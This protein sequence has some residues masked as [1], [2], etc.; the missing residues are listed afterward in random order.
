MDLYPFKSNLG[1]MEPVAMPFHNVRIIYGNEIYYRQVL[2][3]EPIPPFQAVDVGA[4]GAGATNANPT[5]ITNLRQFNH[6][7][8]QFRW[9]PIDH[10]QVTM[11]LPQADGKFRMKQLI[12]PVDE[13]VIERDPD[14]HLTE[15]FVWEANAPWVTCLNYTDYNI[16]R[17]RIVAMGY[18]YLVTKEELPGEVVQQIN[19]GQVPCVTVICTG[20]AGATR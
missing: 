11:Y 19:Q 12:V 18:R 1:G 4:I 13:M 3:M 5:E 9:Y 14:L 10:M 8:G 20:F 6:E 15:I 7:F 2:Q 17:S 16:A